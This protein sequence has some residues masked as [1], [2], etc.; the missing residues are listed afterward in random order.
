VILFLNFLFI[1][2]LINSFGRELFGVISVTWMVLAN[3]A[4][5][6]FGFSR[7]SA[8]FV[9]Q[10]LAA[11]RME[12]AALWSWTA[13]FTQAFLGA[14]GTVL[15][16]FLAPTLVALLHVEPER[17]E[18]VTLA[19]RL[20]AFSIPLDLAARSM[21]GVLQAGQR[22]DWIN[23]LNL[24]GT[25]WTFAVYAAGIWRGAD[26]LVVIYGLFAL[27]IINLVGFY[28]GAARILPTLKTFPKL[29]SITKSYRSL[30]T[31]MI[32]FGWWVSMAAFLGPLLLYFDQWLIGI[33]LGVAVLPFYVVPLNVLSRLAIFPASLTSTLF[34][35]FSAM[36]AKTEWE[37][38]EGYF[39]RSNRY[40]LIALIPLLF[41]LFVWASE[42]LRLWISDEFAAQ[43]ML[44]LRILIFGF[45][46]GLLAPI[47]GALLEGI[48]RPDL[49]V[50]LYLI[51]LPFNAA[52][53][54]ILT[55]R[56]G[57]AGA[58]FSYTLRAIIET[59]A[60]WIVL[61]RALPFSWVKLLKAGLLRTGVV[62][63]VIAFGAY[64][65]GE[66]RIESRAAIIETLVMLAVYSLCVFTF[67]LDKQD[68]DIL[69]SLRGRD[70]ES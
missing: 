12:R 67:L 59:L 10:D 64:F 14:C 17:R 32:R 66:A 60:L 36:Q 40:V 15:L 33:I 54:L 34:P 69:K 8:R 26:F 45:G 28:C 70:L 1:P 23:G 63:L 25:A 50:K 21:S 55:R 20:F 43:A 6:D 22:F 48:G 37:R 57:I 4:W 11:G 39:I 7:A 68:R 18:L 51:E 38:I 56:F 41:I 65:I 5:L 29:N 61:Y 31:E 13:V 42:I 58:A 35:A 46:I 27:R 52:L 47:S 62:V 44:P 2:L 49:L 3:L 19:L 24:F 30:A 53:V 9:A 16:F